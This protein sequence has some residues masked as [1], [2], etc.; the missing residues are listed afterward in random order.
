[1]AQRGAPALSSHDK[2][3]GLSSGMELD[4][5]QVI[6]TSYSEYKPPLSHVKSHNLK[7]GMKGTVYP[8]VIFLTYAPTCFFVCS[9]GHGFINV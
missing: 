7:T 4:Q 1:M 2:T 8:S 9:S 6:D 3:S 5:N